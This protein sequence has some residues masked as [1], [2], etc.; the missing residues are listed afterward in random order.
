MICWRLIAAVAGRGPA[1]IPARNTAS[2]LS[3][4]TRWPGAI[5]CG[6]KKPPFLPYTA[7]VPSLYAPN[8]FLCLL[9]R[10]KIRMWSTS[11]SWRW[12]Y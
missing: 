3:Q 6:T 7:R 4:V 11:P 9:A 2:H 10:R 5:P 1:V 8:A 12:P